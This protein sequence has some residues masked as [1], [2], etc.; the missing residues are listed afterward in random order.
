MCLLSQ[1]CYLTEPAVCGLASPEAWTPPTPPLRAVDLPPPH[2]SPSWGSG[3]QNYLS[4]DR[5]ATLPTSPLTNEPYLQIRLLGGGCSGPAGDSP[6]SCLH[7]SSVP[8]LVGRAQSTPSRKPQGGNDTLSSV[9]AD[10]YLS[11]PAGTSWTTVPLL[12][13]GTCSF[14]AHKAALPQGRRMSGCHTES[15]QTCWT[16]T[17]TR[18]VAFLRFPLTTVPPHVSPS[19]GP[20]P[21]RAP[22]RPWGTTGGC[23]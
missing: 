21:T 17:I 8:S 12:L 11:P 13:Q 7:P 19:H 9:H 15:T 6:A 20:S 14:P 1:D 23:V 3:S 4:S 10:L 2:L 22:F 18:A 16:V 5:K